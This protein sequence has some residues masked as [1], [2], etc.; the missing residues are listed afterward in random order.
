VFFFKLSN[1]SVSSSS[2]LKTSREAPTTGG[3]TEFENKYGLPF[4]LRISTTSFL[5]AVYPPVAPPRAFPKVELI[6]SIYPSTPK[7]SG[8]PLPV[9]PKTPVAWHSSTNVNALYFL[10]SSMIYGR[11]AISP[12]IEKTPSVTITLNLLS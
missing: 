10:A 8:V 12:S 6:T 7:C 4:Y 1:S 2:I 5:L 11:G 3:A 9:F